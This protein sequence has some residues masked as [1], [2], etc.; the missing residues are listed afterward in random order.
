M[1]RINER[2]VHMWISLTNEASTNC[3]IDLGIILAFVV[4]VI[5][6]IAIA[7]AYFV[8]RA[9]VWMNERGW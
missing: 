1:D 3:L 6:P 7:C 2:A 8:P 9:I 5:L 4:C